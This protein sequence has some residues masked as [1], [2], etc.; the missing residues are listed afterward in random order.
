[1]PVSSPDSPDARR[2]AAKRTACW[3]ASIA[4]GFYG[5]FIYLTSRGAG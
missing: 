3:V 5:M 4:I 2:A 1:V